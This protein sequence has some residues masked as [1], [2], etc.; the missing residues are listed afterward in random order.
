M[1]QIDHDWPKRGASSQASVLADAVRRYVQRELDLPAT[2]RGRVCLLTHLT[3]LGIAFN[4]VSFY[5]IFDDQ[6]QRVDYVVAEVNNIPWFEQH[7]YVLR[8]TEYMQSAAPS[9]SRTDS[10]VGK[11]HAPL[12]DEDCI[13][14]ANEQDQ[15]KRSQNRNGHSLF[16]FKE[17]SRWSPDE[18]ESL[19]ASGACGMS[20]SRWPWWRP[21][22][23]RTSSTS[24]LNGSARPSACFVICAAHPKAFHV[25]PFIAME[26]IEYKWLFSHPG[27][28]QMR[29]LVE[30]CQ[31]RP[32]TP[33]TAS[34]P[35]GETSKFFGASLKLHR[36]ELSALNLFLCLL[37]YPLITLQAMLA[38][39]YEATKLYLRGFPFYPH[40]RE[41]KSILSRLITFVVIFV[42][43]VRGAFRLVGYFLSRLFLPLRLLIPSR[44]WCTIRRH[45]S[46]HEPHS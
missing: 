20:A 13:Q 3:Y 37:V 25:S 9:L 15:Q 1:R 41:T 40:P 19:A 29:V 24:S 5:Y 42:E 21:S 38:I 8:A 33:A 26:G 28:R 4:P 31:K 39:H 32:Q 43:R 17:A 23:E 36:V 27:T 30:L 14:P 35:G 18:P 34:S 12:D 2:P 6:D 44:W 10:L 11:A 45:R 16:D 7:A 46:V 22:M